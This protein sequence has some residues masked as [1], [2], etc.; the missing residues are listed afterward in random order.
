MRRI[1][2]FG[3]IILFTA[4]KHPFYLSVTEL[5]YNEKEKA[6]QGS[7]KLFTN[8]LEDA[9]K[10]IHQQTVDLINPKDTLH[11]KKLLAAYLKKRLSIQ[12]NGE[13]KSYDLIG[14]EREQDAIWLYIE[15]KNCPAPKKID[16]ENSLLYDFIKEQMNIVHFEVGGEKKSLKVNYPEKMLSFNFGQ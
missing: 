7:V 11:T 3:L 14:F 9:L 12:V 1:L 2:I 15:L 16:I 5:K 6:L 10:K 13:P 4:F 8:D